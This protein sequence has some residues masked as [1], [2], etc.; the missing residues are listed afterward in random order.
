[1]K[2]R[3]N[4]GR[5]NKIYLINLKKKKFVLKKYKKKHT[6]KFDRYTTEKKFLIFL[7]NKNILNVPK[8]VLSDKEKK[9]NT[10]S[11]I[12]GKHLKK[13]KRKYLDKCLK[14]I[15]KLN[16]GTDSKNFKFQKAAD[17][18]L[19]INDHINQ[20]EK[21]LKKLLRKYKNSKLENN[22][23]IYSF[24]TEKIQPNFNE[25]KKQLHQEY[26]DYLINLKIKN[27]FLI[28]SP[29][30][31]GFH[32]ILVSNDE[33]FFIDF[34]YAGWDDPNKLVC[35]FLLNPDYCISKINQI[36]FIKKFSYIF[37]N[38]FSFSKKFILL[39]K[40]HFLKWVCVILNYVEIKNSTKYANYEYFKKAKNYFRNNLNILK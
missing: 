30:D 23:K 33:T 39:K 21:R 13:V 22:Q 32:N 5:N 28:L 29:S 27:K 14:F 26:S 34:E 1:M 24:L 18:C 8:L 3:I 2:K 40:I 12:K 38:K 7:H 31:F 4:F 15:K 35:D 16:E 10:L 36:Y 25:V 6:S 11:F 9:I 20:C 19:S 37:K 17:A